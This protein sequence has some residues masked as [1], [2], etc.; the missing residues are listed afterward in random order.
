MGSISWSE[1][2]ISALQNS[3]DE[4]LLSVVPALALR[5]PGRPS[6]IAN[7]ATSES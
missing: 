1:L 6:F 3:A 5:T 4:R 7:K 2:R